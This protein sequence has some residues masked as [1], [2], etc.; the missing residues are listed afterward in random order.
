[1]AVFCIFLTVPWVGLNSV[2]VALPG[3][4]HFLVK[5]AS[6]YKLY[7]VC[8]FLDNTFNLKLFP[9][10]QYKAIRFRKPYLLFEHLQ[11]GINNIN[12]S[13]SLP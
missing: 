12:G 1:M 8:F 6:H 11:Y 10:T 3:H 7:C 9:T 5:S 4:I 2:I 13:F